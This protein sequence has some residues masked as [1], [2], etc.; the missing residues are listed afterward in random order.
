MGIGMMSWSPSGRWLASWNRAS[1]SVSRASQRRR[2]EELTAALAR[3]E[4]YPTTLLLFSF[5]SSPTPHFHPRLHTLLVHNLPVRGFEW[6]SSSAGGEGQELLAITT[7]QKG[8][9]MWR[10]PR[11]DVAGEEEG[12]A[13]C[14]GVPSRELTS[15][16][17]GRVSQVKDRR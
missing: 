13:E 5:I 15:S 9:T 12:L 10:E 11:S 2:D 3:V 7:A 6:Q 1:L 8:F 17:L 16:P 4:S 14:V